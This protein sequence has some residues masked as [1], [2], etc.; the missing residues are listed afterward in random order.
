MRMTTERDYAAY[1]EVDPATRVLK[2]SLDAD[3]AC[4]HSAFLFENGPKALASQNPALIGEAAQLTTSDRLILSRYVHEHDHLYRFVY[5]P[6]G[7]LLHRMRSAEVDSFIK[8]LVDQPPRFRRIDSVI[9]AIEGGYRLDAPPN[10]HILEP[11]EDFADVQ[12]RPATETDL[13]ERLLEYFDEQQPAPVIG[14]YAL[15][16]KAL[17][18]LLAFNRE[19]TIAR[20]VASANQEWPSFLQPNLRGMEDYNRAQ[21]AWRLIVSDPLVAPPAPRPTWVAAGAH[22]TRKVLPLEIYLAADLALWMPLQPPGRAA[23]RECAWTDFHP[24]WRFLRASLWLGLNSRPFASHDEF[25]GSFEKKYEPLINAICNHFG[26]PRPRALA[27]AWLEWSR[28]AYASKTTRR[29]FIEG[30]RH[31]LMAIGDLLNTWKQHPCAFSLTLPEFGQRQHLWFSAI[32]TLGGR[33]LNPCRPVPESRMPRVYAVSNA[34]LL[35][36]RGSYNRRYFNRNCLIVRELVDYARDFYGI[37]AS[38]LIPKASQSISEGH[39]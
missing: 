14:G 28:E 9:R 25:P 17:L 32:E 35:L 30:D 37:D 19:I 21:V 22:P 6:Y 31:R 3:E 7:H 8:S 1:C 27:D 33:I 16:G 29:Y 20:Y 26:W 36:G 10:R 24:G 34:Q 2:V 15:G 11:L 23:N 38:Y 18:E 4:R 13:E 12:T 39:G 5:S